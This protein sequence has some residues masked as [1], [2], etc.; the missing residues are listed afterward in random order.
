MSS[1]Q[2]KLQRARINGICCAADGEIHPFSKDLVTILRA[3]EVGAKVGF[4]VKLDEDHVKR[5]HEYLVARDCPGIG[6][7]Y[8]NPS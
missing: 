1:N 2:E 6:E 7:V 4:K 3:I 8:G 5:L